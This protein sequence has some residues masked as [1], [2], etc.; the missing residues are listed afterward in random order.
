MADGLRVE[1]VSDPDAVAAHRE[2]WDALACAVPANTPAQGFDYAM[3]AWRVCAAQGGRLAVIL[4]WREAALLAVWPLHV[5]REGGLRRVRH[6]G[7]GNYEEYADPLMAAGP[8]Q[9]EVADAICRAACG[10]GDVLEAYNIAA[11]SAVDAWLKA[12]SRTTYAGAMRS[13]LVSCAGAGDWDAWARGKTKNFRA[14]LRADRKKLSVHGELAFREVGEGEAETFVAW[15]LDQKR[16]WLVEANRRSS[17]LPQ[18]AVQAFFADTVGRRGGGVLGFVL[19]QGGAPVAGALCLRSATHLEF[20]VSALDPAFAPYSPG[21]LL[22]E[23]VVRW[24]IAR[25]LDFDFRLTREPYKLR[26]ADSD[27]LVTTYWVA[28]TWRGAVAV[29]RRQF[30]DAVVAAKSWLKARISRGAPAA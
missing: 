29:R 8:F 26:W 18:T 25:R 24:S 20:Y 28:C 21:K 7:C 5:T 9:A 1:I 22:I 11:D 23:D 15:M 3:A 13:P 10:L 27:R 17:W 6:L 30:Q 19:E 2:A 14:G 16:R 4:A 12:Q